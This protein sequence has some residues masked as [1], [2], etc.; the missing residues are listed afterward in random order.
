M[1]YL[2]ALHLHGAKPFE[3]LAARDGTD[4]NLGMGAEYAE[5][6]PIRVGETLAATPELRV[7]HASREENQIRSIR[8]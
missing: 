2:A 5:G 3:V 6:E 7:R 1:V 8:H 4:R